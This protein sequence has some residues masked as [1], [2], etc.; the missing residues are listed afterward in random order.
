[1]LAAS[2]VRYVLPDGRQLFA[3][4]NLALTPGQAI[5]ITGPSGTGKSTL[6]ALLGG[7]LQPTSGLVKHSFP[8]ERAFAWVLQA[9]NGLSARTTLAN[10][11]LLA[12]LD[13]DP[14][15]AV[16]SKAEQLLDEV[17]LTS[18]TFIKAR[19]LSGGE[20]QRLAVVRA[21]TSRRP[22]ILAD[23]PTSH[24]DRHNAQ[25]VMRTLVKSAAQ[26]DRIVVVVT[27]DHDALPDRCRSFALTPGG[28]V[29]EG[30][31]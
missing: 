31:T 26:D 23:E 25:Q 12:L 2:S 21:L 24:L 17:E 8:R 30:T 1:M 22:I 7:L 11:C 3:G 16:R 10:A 28:L 4:V 19:R 27:H 18:R 13:G 9:L 15:S 20:L 6:L 5:A 29:D 14:R